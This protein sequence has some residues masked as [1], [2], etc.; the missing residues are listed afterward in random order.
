[1]ASIAKD[2]GGRKRILFVAPDG[3]RKAI[4]LGKVP[5]K[6]TE[7][8]KHKVESLLAAK[9]TGDA[10]DAE[11]ARWVAELPDDLAGKLAA[12]ALIPERDKATLGAFLE[13]YILSRHDAKRG[14]IDHLR[15]VRRDLIDHSGTGKLLRDI[16][17]G[18]ADGFRLFLIGRGLAENTVRRRCGRA[19]QLFTA[20]VRR[21]LIPANPFS[22]LK[23]AV[24]ANTSRFYF[25]TRE[26][27]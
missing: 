21:Q 20:G 11:T 23:S 15:R 3:R 13:T 10:V 19:K 25:F 26:E 5:Q 4:R 27:T 2:P 6:A 14:T 24:Q 17:P 16:S 18:E 22:D 8:V 1:M 7:K 9:I 12:V